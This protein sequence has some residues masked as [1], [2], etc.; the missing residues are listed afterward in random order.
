MKFYEVIIPA[1]HNSFNSNGPPTTISLEAENEEAARDK[2]SERTGIGRLVPTVRE[3]GPNGQ[4]LPPIDLYIE[5]TSQNHF[6]L[7]LHKQGLKISDRAS[8][9]YGKGQPY[10]A[11][12]ALRGHIVDVHRALAATYAHME[13]APVG[14]LDA[15]E[16]YYWWLCSTLPR[17]ATA[18]TPRPTLAV[19]CNAMLITLD[20]AFESASWTVQC[21]AAQDEYARHLRRAVQHLRECLFTLPRAEC[22]AAHAQYTQALIP[23]DMAIGP[24]ERQRAGR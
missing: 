24:L 2:V 4:S 23:E 7:E 5:I 1:S 16:E 11:K 13:K 10:E 22:G 20:H 18:G 21:V 19:L 6:F 15:G 14:P 17:L 12:Q 8:D 3:V 9:L